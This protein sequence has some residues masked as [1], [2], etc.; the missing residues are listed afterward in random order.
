M[1]VG[2]G[3]RASPFWTESKFQVLAHSFFGSFYERADVLLRRSLFSKVGR[4]PRV[5]GI[6]DARTFAFPISSLSPWPRIRSS[7]SSFSI[8]SSPLSFSWRSVFPFGPLPAF[9][10]PPN[11]P[12]LSPLVQ[13]APSLAY[14]PPALHSSRLWLDPPPRS[15][16]LPRVWPSFRFPIQLFQLLASWLF[17]WWFHPV[18]PIRTIRVS[19]HVQ[20]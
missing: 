15:S 19:N 12:F 6:L 18:V 20:F 2:H 9:S 11:Q 1:V 14:R 17:S 5:D 10:R 13:P 3:S 16:P 7:S 4:E 8:L